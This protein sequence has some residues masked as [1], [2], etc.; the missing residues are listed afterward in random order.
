[1][2]PLVPASSLLSRPVVAD[3]FPFFRGAAATPSCCA[4]ALP[5]VFPVPVLGLRTCDGTDGFFFLDLPSVDGVSVL[6]AVLWLAVSLV[7]PE[8]HGEGQ[9]RS[10]VKKQSPL[11]ASMFCSPPSFGDSLSECAIVFYDQVDEAKR[12]KNN[13]V[14]IPPKVNRKYVSRHTNNQEYG[15]NSEFF[16]GS[17]DECERQIHC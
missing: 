13:K 2:W 3:F 16:S 7:C 17:F 8:H 5:E 1:M 9:R 10:T 15:S 11:R 14:K 12:K 4:V 6:A